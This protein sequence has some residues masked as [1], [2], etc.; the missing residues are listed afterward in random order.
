MAAWNTARREPGA[1]L[2]HLAHLSPDVA[3]LPELAKVP[4]VAPARGSFVDFGAPGAPGVGV[5]GQE[6]WTIAGHWGDIR[7]G[8]LSH[9]PIVERLG[10]L[11]LHSG[12]HAHRGVAQGEDEESTYWHSGGGT[13]MI[14]HVFVP[15]PWRIHNVVVGAERPWRSWSDHAPVLVDVEAP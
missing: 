4:M 3:V 5:V 11:G 1:Q 2:D 10:E 14:D 6:P 12:Y 9:L 8:P 13:Y 7:S 15:R